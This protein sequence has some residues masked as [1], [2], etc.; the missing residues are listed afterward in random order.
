MEAAAAVFRGP[1]YRQRA[2]AR[3]AEKE[4]STPTAWLP[5]FSDRCESK[6][7]PERSCRPNRPVMLVQKFS[8]VSISSLEIS[9]EKNTT[10]VNIMQ[11][12]FS[13]FHKFFIFS[14]DGFRH[15]ALRS[16]F[17][18]RDA[19]SFL[20]LSAVLC[21]FFLS[22]GKYSLCYTAFIIRYDRRFPAWRCLWG[23]VPNSPAATGAG[24]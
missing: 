5:V 20:Y 22:P 12:E 9:I 14:L 19:R 18:R 3:F 10:F 7:H 24:C 11:E 4:K 15:P 8:C 16:A 2:K 23:G 6:A 17:W 21:V 1:S 13:V